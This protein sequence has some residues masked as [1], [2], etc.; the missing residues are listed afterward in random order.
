MLG[1]PGHNVH[2]EIQGVPALILDCNENIDLRDDKDIDKKAEYA[3]K[4]RV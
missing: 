4:V 2:P 3:H 1:T